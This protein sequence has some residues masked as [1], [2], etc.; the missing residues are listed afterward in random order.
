MS[1]RWKFHDGFDPAYTKLGYD[2]RGWETVDVPHCPFPV[3]F[4]YF[5][6][7]S[8]WKSCTY[9]KEVTLP[10]KE[11]WE[12][13]VRFEG[14]GVKATVFFDG[15]ILAVHEGA[16]TPFE[17][18]LPADRGT[19]V[20]RVDTQEDPQIP[21][22]G[23]AVDY[24]VFGGIYR[25]VTFFVRPVAHLDSFFVESEDGKTVAVKLHATCK[26][27]K[28]RLRLKD[29]SILLAEGETMIE[30][31]N[32]ETSFS[33]LSLQL[34]DLKEPKLYHM[35]ATFGDDERS[36]TFGARKAE[37]TFSGFLLNG[38]RIKL[39]GLDRHQCY[40]Y[41][42]YAMPDE[43]QAHDART[44]KEMGLNIVRTSHYPDSPAF[45]D[46][47]DRLGLLVLEEIPGWQHIGEDRHWRKLCVENVKAMVERDINHPSVVLWG[48]RINESQDDDELYRETNA[49]A[50]ALD[51]SRQTCGIRNFLSSNLLEDVFTYNDFSHDGNGR[52]L[53]Q[54]RINAPY[55]VTEHNG[56]MFPTKR[57]DGQETRTGQ[58]LRH[59]A[60]LESAFAN[61]RISGAIGWCF[62]D[63]QTHSNF[64][65]GDGICYHGVCDQ[66]RVPKFGA[67]AY[68][69][70]QEKHPVLVSSQT[71]DS[72]DVPASKDMPWIIAT[73]CEYVNLYCDGRFVKRF[74]PCRKRYPHVPHPPVFVDDFIGERI[75]DESVFSAK[76]RKLVSRLV[77]KSKS[78]GTEFSLSDKVEL[79]KLAKRYHLD[80]GAVISLVNKYTSLDRQR[81]PVWTLDGVIGGKVVASE[82]YGPDQKR[83]VRALAERTKVVLGDGY[84]VIPVIL[85]VGREG[86]TLPL[87]Y[88]FEPYLVKTEG[89]VSLL[90]PSMDATIG[91]V[92]GIYVRTT[93]EK[94]KGIVRIQLQRETVAVEI[95]IV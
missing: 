81:K 25:K 94:G 22:F 74:Y 16:Y 9:R 34:W 66:H 60:V 39:I 45:L 63:Y 42:G 28:V 49:V 82:T 18:T 41:V 48:V 84:Q 14:V 13:I 43:N 65:S 6:E 21:P 2:D 92:G 52:G 87:P 85:T 90:S 76:D 72:G 55:L 5:D 88:A 31:G 57:F 1:D 80:H 51:P 70:Q 53:V 67:Y 37:V 56:H 50:H 40:P 20:V 95:D 32:A 59:M 83:I 33:G 58:F 29:E 24:L 35:E 15:V 12:R 54:P 77:V 17:V 36:V 26:K 62:A 47:C 11:G 3:P 23:G 73:N 71:F 91:G 8:F 64:G 30:N 68:I 93:G 89:P 10:A 69:S 79:S 4:Q 44:L 86:M 7:T 19:L 38:K 78:A 27:G 46:A 61:D 75:A